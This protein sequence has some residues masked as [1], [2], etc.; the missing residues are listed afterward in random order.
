MRLEIL[1]DED[2]TTVLKL[3]LVR[4]RFG[5]NVMGVEDNGDKW[6]LL[7]LKDTGTVYLYTAVPEELGFQLD[8]NNRIKIKL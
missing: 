2:N 4:D 1:G 6:H 8:D 7:S 3:Q 5:V